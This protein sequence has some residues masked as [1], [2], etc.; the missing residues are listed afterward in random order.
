MRNR[1]TT[2]IRSIIDDNNDRQTKVTETILLH[3]ILRAEIISS[4]CMSMIEFS[5]MRYSVKAKSEIEIIEYLIIR[6]WCQNQKE[7]IFLKCKCLE[8]IICDDF[9][10]INFAN[11]LYF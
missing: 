2:H 7:T 4:E 9:E 1:V 11:C 3:D 6:M 5:W 8:I 10:L